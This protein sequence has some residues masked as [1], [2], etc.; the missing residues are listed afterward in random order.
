MQSDGDIKVNKAGGISVLVKL[1]DKKTGTVPCNKTSPGYC[2]STSKGT[3]IR[4]RF[5]YKWQ[6]TQIAVV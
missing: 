3:C 4:I 1:L 6:K 2:G 5:R